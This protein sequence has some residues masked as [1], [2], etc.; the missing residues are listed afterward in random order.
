[1]QDHLQ[2]PGT[3]TTFAEWYDGEAG[4]TRIRRR[5][6][7]GIGMKTM[8]VTSCLLPS[9]PRLKPW[10]GERK[11]PEAIVRKRTSPQREVLRARIILFC[12]FVPMLLRTARSNVNPAPTSIQSSGAELENRAIESAQCYYA[13][14]LHPYGWTHT[15]RS[16]AANEPAAWQWHL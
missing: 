14:R 3:R 13:Y 7:G 5:G 4:L 12:A 15:R 10:T 16:L 1:M 2:A 6:A 8:D 9:A 11:R